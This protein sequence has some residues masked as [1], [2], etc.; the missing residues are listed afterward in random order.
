MKVL[1]IILIVLMA[2]FLGLHLAFPAAVLGISITA[3]L[4]YAIVGS[5]FLFC[6]LILLLFVVTGLGLLFLTLF[7]IGWFV[8]ALIL[9]PFLLPILLPLLLLIFFISLFRRQQA[10]KNKLQLTDESESSS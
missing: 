4:W 7:A 1:A 6:A 3:G 2:F 9:F 10:R 5:I 8:I